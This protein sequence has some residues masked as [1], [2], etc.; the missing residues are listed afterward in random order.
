MCDE[1]RLRK[2]AGDIMD[3]RREITI[4]LMLDGCKLGTYRVDFVVDE[5]DGTQEF[6]EAKGLAFAVWKM[7]WSILQAMY[8]NDKTK[9]FR[10]VTA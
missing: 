8:R 10:V 3:Y 9:K 1:L 6:V 5:W 2:I 4:Q 7:K